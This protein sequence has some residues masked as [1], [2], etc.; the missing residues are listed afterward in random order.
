MTQPW[1][2]FL[3]SPGQDLL[4][5]ELG[6][7][8]RMLPDIFGYYLL[9]VGMPGSF[10][11][12]VR[13]S[14][15]RHHVLL[16]DVAAGVGD[17][18]QAIAEPSQLPI[19]T[20]SIDVVILPHTLDFAHEPHQVLREAERVL[21]PEGRLILFGFNP[22]SLWGLWRTLR[23]SGAGM[24]ASGN[25]ISPFRVRDWLSVL[26][27]DLEQQEPLMFRPPLGAGGLMR[28]LVFLDRVGRIL[29][30]AFAGAYALRAVKRVSTLTPIRPSWLV[31]PRVIAGRA[32]EPTTRSARGV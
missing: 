24:P 7:L 4:D 1:R 8:E 11:R 20:D 5:L 16:T 26:G 30:P 18:L 6:C 21:I 2:W 10:R 32:A 22:W 28:R 27:F 9:Q 23:S 13:I 12:I 15:V 3:E 29:W 17:P 25:A 31:R 14:R 19:A